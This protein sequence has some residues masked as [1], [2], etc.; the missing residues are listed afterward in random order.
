MKS[1]WRDWALRVTARLKPPLTT[2]TKP[3]LRTGI[4]E[5]SSQYILARIFTQV[6]FCLQLPATPMKTGKSRNSCSRM[7]WKRSTIFLIYKIRIYFPSRKHK[8]QLCGSRSR[9][10]L[11]SKKNICIKHIQEYQKT[12]RI[13]VQSLI[14]DFS[15]YENPTDSFW[16]IRK[17]SLK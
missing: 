12:S 10:K 8:S 17:I 7:I 4:P 6:K 15:L 14:F 1:L 5:G 9:E 3:I 13:I 11:L 16:K 2:E